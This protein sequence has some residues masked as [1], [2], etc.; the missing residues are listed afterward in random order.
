MM[1]DQQLYGKGSRNLMQVGI[2][3]NLMISSMLQISL[4]IQ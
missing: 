4:N 2:V 3:S 1:P